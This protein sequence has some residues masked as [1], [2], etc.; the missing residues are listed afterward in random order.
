MTSQDCL[1]FIQELIVKVELL[2]IPT[3]AKELIIYDIKIQ[4]DIL[5][6]QIKMGLEEQGKDESV[7]VITGNAKLH[8]LFFDKLDVQALHGSAEDIPFEYKS[9][10]LT[11]ETTLFY[12]LTY[13]INYTSEEIVNSGICDRAEIFPLISL[14][15]ENVE[16]V[17]IYGRGLVPC[18][19]YS[20]NS[21]RL[22]SQQLSNQYGINACPIYSADA[23]ISN[24][25]KA[26]AQI[27]LQRVVNNLN[28]VDEMQL[29]WEQ[30]SDFRKDKESRLSYIHFLSYLRERWD[31]Y[32]K[33][34]FEYEIEKLYYEYKRAL[35]KHG[36]M[37]RLGFVKDLFS[38]EVVLPTA[39]SSVASYLIK[40]ELMPF[41]TGTFVVGSIGFKMLEYASDVEYEKPDAS[42]AWLIGI[43]EHFD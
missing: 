21:I 32:D 29:E 2:P 19:S 9:R 3:I 17:A 7:A 16:K 12:L 10:Y 4:Q 26:G 30:V 18:N 15:V 11:Y 27:I 5:F 43:E 42:I 39:L 28:I 6:R 41:I 24:D 35:K 37:T 36:V 14:L 38:T 13:I 40:P 34:M 20:N 8:A 23:E 25:F 22:Y 33:K 31:I 1:S